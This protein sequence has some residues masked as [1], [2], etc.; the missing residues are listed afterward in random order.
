M[1]IG[2]DI[3]GVLIDFEERLR[4]RA[5]MFDYETRNRVFSD[6]DDVYWVQDK[7]DWTKDEW[8]VFQKR[9][10]LDLSRESCIKLGAQEILKL[11]K[12]E[13]NELVVISAR[14]L[15]SEE[16]ITIVESLI[17]SY[18]IEFDKYY[19]KTP[20]KVGVCLNEK[21]DITIDDNPNTC[22][23]LSLNGIKT[24]Y[25]RNVYGKQLQENNY[26]KEVRDWADVYK[27]IK[28]LGI[29]D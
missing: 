15:E 20:D 19:W 9:Y 23:S 2:V 27:V 21:I 14:G 28:S 10:L 16:M 26:L 12:Q 18:N 17:N 29:K 25:F 4:Y 5:S 22:N 3:D 8:E 13:G 7:Y 24:L 6:S 11:L 1:K